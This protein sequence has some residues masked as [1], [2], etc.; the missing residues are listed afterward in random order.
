M[1]R[2]IFRKLLMMHLL[3]C[4]SILLLAQDSSKIFFTTAVGLLHP[5]SAFSNAYQNSLALN[6]GIEY[7]LGKQYFVQFVIDFNAVKYSQQ[8]KDDN[9]AYLFQKT[10]SSVLLAGFNIGKDFPLI[11]SGKL[12]VSPYVGIGYVN[13]GE[14]RLMVDTVNRIITQQVERKNGLFE[15]LGSRLAYSTT[16][17]V[18]Q[19]V[20]IDLS[21]W[22]SSIKVQQSNPK[23]FSFLIGT[24]FGF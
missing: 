8:L 20:Y 7:K 3:S 14:P 18:L 24:R 11:R 2:L 23:A 5:V 16:S 21:Y 9:A 19:T 22:T 17:K 4:M 15:R 10:S 6:S 13:I 1:K 12:F